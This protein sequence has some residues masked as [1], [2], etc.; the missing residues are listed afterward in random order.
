MLYQPRYPKDYE[1]VTLQIGR[2]MAL[3]SLTASNASM[4]E[5]SN[6]AACCATAIQYTLEQSW[7][8]EERFLANLNRNLSS[9]L[10]NVWSDIEVDPRAVIEATLPA[11][12]DIRA[13]LYPKGE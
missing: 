1:N 4:S 11:T 8:T 7:P 10:T 9:I 2:K 12:E 6:L 3:D 5:L 13:E